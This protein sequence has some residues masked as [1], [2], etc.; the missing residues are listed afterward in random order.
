MANNIIVDISV[1][2]FVVG[3]IFMVIMKILDFIKN[4]KVVL[5]IKE[6]RKSMPMFTIEDIGRPY[7]ALG[8]VSSSHWF[9]ERVEVDIINQAEEMGADAIIGLDGNSE[10]VRDAKI[11]KGGM[12]NLT[13]DPSLYKVKTTEKTTYFMKG[14]AVKFL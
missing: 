14:T 11:D 5:S 9:R 10:T 2:V 4:A 12:L 1:G 13:N 7:T 3:T 6:K 8:I